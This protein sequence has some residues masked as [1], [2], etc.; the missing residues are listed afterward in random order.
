[1]RATPV[2]V[3]STLL[4]FLPG[5]LNA[6]KLQTVFLEE[7]DRYGSEMKD[8]NPGSNIWEAPPSLKT[9]VFSPEKY[10]LIRKDHY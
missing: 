6:E 7:F 1:M 4:S 3:C 8:F 2:L 5:I 9:F 10:S